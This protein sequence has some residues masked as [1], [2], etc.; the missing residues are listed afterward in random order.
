MAGRRQRDVGNCGSRHGNAQRRARHGGQ[1]EVLGRD[2]PA[3][4]VALS[5]VAAEVVDQLEGV[6]VF[7]S[8]GDDAQAQRMGEVDGRA[9]DRHRSP[10]LGGAGEKRAVELQLTD[11]QPA[12]VSQ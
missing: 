6:E 11:R 2:G 3:H 10:V 5:R 12:Y 4:Q 7:N 9:N 1:I 8:L